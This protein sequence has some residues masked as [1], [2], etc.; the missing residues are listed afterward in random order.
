MIGVPGYLCDTV[1]WAVEVCRQVGSAR[2]KVLFDIFH[3]QLHFVMFDRIT[4]DGACRTLAEHL[5]DQVTRVRVLMRHY[6]RVFGQ[7][8]WWNA[9]FLSQRV[10]WRSNQQVVDVVRR[11]K[12][13]C[14]ARVARPRF[15]RQGLVAR[16]AV[17]RTDARSP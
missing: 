14:L 16:T 5:V 4:R 13:D 11:F 3:V 10:S 6:E 2:M 17:W 15:E 8:G 9:S 12:C 7:V 1:K